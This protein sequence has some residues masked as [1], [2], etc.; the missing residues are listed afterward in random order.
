MALVDL[1]L[2]AFTVLLTILLLLK[3]FFG[4]ATENENNNENGKSEH[5]F[6]STEY[7]YYR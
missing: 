2:I 5:V 1:L 3:K 6:H 4:V 7:A